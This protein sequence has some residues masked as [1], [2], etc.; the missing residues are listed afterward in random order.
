MTDNTEQDFE[1]AF[2]E[3]VEGEAAEVIEPQPQEPE[4]TDDEGAA[5]TEQREH[6]AEP[7]PPSAPET[8]TT[9]IWSNA[10]EEQRAAFEAAQKD[11]Q[12]W[13]HRVE[14]DDGRVSRFQRER[15]ELKRQ[16]ESLQKVGEKAAKED[17]TE[18]LK[19][20]DWGKIK[21]EYEEL[22]PLLAAIEQVAQQNLTVA[23]RLGQMDQESQQ[24]YLLRQQ[25]ALTER[26]PDWLDLVRHEGF[27]SWIETQPRHLRDAFERNRQGVV[28][29]DE[30]NDVVSRYREH[31]KASES[32]P[33]SDPQKQTI[34]RKR[35]A[36]MNGART[37]GSR[38]PAMVADPAGD[39]FEAHFR[40]AVAEDE[41]KSARR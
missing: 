37:I 35:Q 26:A 18:L 19:S 11:A 40:N 34:D 3:A 2:K 13:R 38:Q 16:I 12:Q 1:A 25:E 7:P 31:L 15:D 4:T 22:N 41:R 6:G 39:D 29:V 9:D 8:T 10:T 30:A 28:D 33:P 27:P 36:Q 14:S 5:P 32:A 17:L 24:A 21:E 20:E 23:E